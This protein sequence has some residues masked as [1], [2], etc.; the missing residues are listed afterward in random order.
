MLLDGGVV[1]AAFR[2]GDLA[3]GDGEAA[4]VVV[5]VG[6]EVGE[7]AGAAEEEC[8]CGSAQEEGAPERDVD[9]PAEPVAT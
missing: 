6:A 4:E 7:L 5:A 8:G 2:A 9:H 1:F 3:V